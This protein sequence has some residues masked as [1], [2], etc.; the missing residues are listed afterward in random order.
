M[1]GGAEGLLFLAGALSSEDETRAG[2]CG[3]GERAG[4]RTCTLLNFLEMVRGVRNKQR[5]NIPFP[6]FVSEQLC[7]CSTSF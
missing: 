2:W 4:S 1:P 6:S 7:F 3:V 5:T